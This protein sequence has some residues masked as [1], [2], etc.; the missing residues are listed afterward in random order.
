M[1][2]VRDTEHV[3]ACSSRNYN[4]PLVRRANTDI[5]PKKPVTL[6]RNQLLIRYGVTSTL[7]R[8]GVTLRGNVTTVYPP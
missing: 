6:H 3:H 8:Y 4:I 1:Y 2:C 5:A 7:L